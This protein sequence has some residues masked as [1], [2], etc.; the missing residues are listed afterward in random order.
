MSFLLAYKLTVDDGVFGAVV[1]KCFC[2]RSSVAPSFV[3]LSWQR[4]FPG[5]MRACS[6]NSWEAKTGKLSSRS[7][8]TTKRPCLPEK[9]G[10]GVCA[11][12]RIWEVRTGL[13]KGIPWLPNKAI[14]DYIISSPQT[15]IASFIK[16]NLIW[17]P[18]VFLL[19]F[20]F[21]TFFN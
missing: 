7:G 8:R 9:G 13:I 11:V 14:L 4:F 3:K 10:R 12:F 18:V 21:L 5:I 16:F 20:F 19:F 6:P 1:A 15:H 2:L 17:N